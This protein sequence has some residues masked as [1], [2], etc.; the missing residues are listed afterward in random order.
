L[1][2][3][4]TRL[5]SSRSSSVGLP[6]RT[7]QKPQERVQTL[8]R[9]M[10]VAVRLFQHSPMFGQRASSQT[11]CSPKPRMVSFMSL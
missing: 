11:V 6:V 8:P 2:A 1:A 4:A 9:I 7:A 5:G 10:K 3:S